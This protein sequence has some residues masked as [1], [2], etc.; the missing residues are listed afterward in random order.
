MNA[1]DKAAPAGKKRPLAKLLAAA[2]AAGLMM[3]GAGMPS[4]VA[5]QEA[6]APPT[7]TK[8]FL[9]VYGPA[10]RLVTGEKKDWQAALALIPGL[11]AAMKNRKD[12]HTVGNFM[13]IVGGEVNDDTLRRKGLEL[14]LKSSLVAEADVPKFHYFIASLAFNDGDK[15]VATAN[16]KRAYETGYVDTDANLLNDA[17]Y[18]VA[19]SYVQ[20]DNYDAAFA[21]LMPYLDTVIASNTVSPEPLIRLGL[22]AAIDS[23]NMAYGNQLSRVL[24]EQAPSEA[25]WKVGLQVVGSMN[26]LNESA[27]LDFLRLMRATG[28]MSQRS[29]YVRYIE[30]ADPRVMS[31]ELEGVLAE[32]VAAGQFQ[33][34][35]DQYYTEVKSII[36]ARKATDRRELN[37]TLADG[38]S[39]D[40]HLAYIAGDILYS[41]DDFTRAAEF[42]AMAADKGHKPDASLLREG[43][44]RTRAA[45]YQAAVATLG[46]VTG[47][48]ALVAQMWALF[49]QQ[50]MPATPTA[51]LPA[52]AAAAN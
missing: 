36:E 14:M 29:E 21:F 48:S 47:D 1:I 35:G 33:T 32:G 19:Q 2:A 5:A 13:L 38:R 10:A 39:G 45:D 42:Y 9:G 4:V 41:L 28:A 16:W 3:A 26:P 7:N 23:N 34:S 22:Q 51:V 8:A 37:S 18:L 27:E 11:E 31:N 30:N 46:E 43:I 24:I 40:G 52:Q 17:G 50:K 20:A 49:A 25:T 6:A 44:S 15:D 12:R